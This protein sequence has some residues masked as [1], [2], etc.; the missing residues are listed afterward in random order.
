MIK[1]APYLLLFLFAV[2]VNAQHARLYANVSGY[3]QSDFET[4]SFFEVGSGIEVKVHRF[5]KPEI[6]VSYFFGSLEDFTKVDGQGNVQSLRTSNANALNFNLTPKISLFSREV[7][8]G[9]GF[10]QILPRF[11]ISK[12]E[13]NRYYTV[14]NQSNPANSVTTKEKVV[15]WQK[16][17]GIGVG[18]D[19]VLSDKNYDSVSL[20]VYYNGVNLGKAVT[21]VNHS[22]AKLDTNTLGFGVSYYL[23]FE[24]KKN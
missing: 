5:F 4:R 9:D 6:G 19:I 14:V 2:Q 3:L 11:N 10:I 18:V 8:S 17:F 24:K 16:S 20:N 1:Q 22:S 13:A 7:N 15:E 12:I 23:G 21:D